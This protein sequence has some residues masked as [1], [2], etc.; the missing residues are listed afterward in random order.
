MTTRVALLSYAFRPSLGGIERVS[1]ILETGL[2]DAGYDVR[3]ATMSSGPDEA[4]V[5][6]LPSTLQLVR[7]LS[8]CDVIVESN[9]SIRLSW[10][11]I[12]RMVKR[13][14]LTVLHTPITVHNG[15]RMAW[16]D[17]AKVRL[18]PRGATY[19]VSRWLGAQLPIRV[20]FMPNPFESADYPH[21]ELT[22]RRGVL[23]VGRLTRAKGLDV[24]L[25]AL[26]LL[27]ERPALTVVG[28]GNERLAL[29]EQARGLGLE[30]RFLGGLDSAGTAAEMTT[31]AVLC[32]PSISQPPEVFPLVAPPLGGA[33]GTRS[34][35]TE[36]SCRN[37]RRKHLRTRW[38]KP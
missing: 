32:I 7:L 27:N 38:R 13:P 18:L 33:S 20:G 14:R 30:V 26:A 6:R 23:F 34:G 36:L 17:D 10:P 22:Q 35:P 15:G 4:N 29:Q 16:I 25:N 28:D 19:A 3:V 37:G 11:A 1:D 8:W 9:V 12:A 24:L 2:R 31:A 21:Q 5:L